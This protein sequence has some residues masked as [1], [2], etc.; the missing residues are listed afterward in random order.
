MGGLSNWPIPDPHLPGGRKVPLWNCSQI[1]NHILSTS[2]GVVER[3]DHHCGDDLV[4]HP[5]VYFFSVFSSYF[6][7]R[8]SF[9]FKDW[10]AHEQSFNKYWKFTCSSRTNIVFWI[11]TCWLM[12]TT[13]LQCSFKTSGSWILTSQSSLL[14]INEN[15]FSNKLQ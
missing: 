3:P 1:G 10:I 12:S 11:H 2:R 5:R 4:P 7:Q 13:N 15:R 14:Q 6:L 8:E 9:P